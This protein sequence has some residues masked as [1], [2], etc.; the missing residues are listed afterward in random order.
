MHILS[1]SM[2]SVSL[3]AFGAGL[4]FAAPAFASKDQIYPSGAAATVTG[5]TAGID[6]VVDVGSSGHATLD[7]ALYPSQQVDVQVTWSIDN[8]RGNGTNTNYGPGL[9]L[10]FAP[11]LEQTAGPDVAVADIPNCTVTSAASTC[12][13]SIKFTAPT[14]AGNYQIAVKADG[15]NEFSGKPSVYLNF[16]V[17]EPVAVLKDTK[18]AVAKQCVLL[19]A[20]SVALEAKLEELVSGSVIAGASVDFSIDSE[21]SITGTSVTDADG[22]ASL[23]FSVNGLA[24]GD[25]T[26]FAEYAGLGGM[27][28]P[29]A[30]SNTLGVSYLF[31]GFQQPINADGTSV[32]GNGRVIPVKIRLADANGQPVSDAA[33]TVWVHQYT[34]G[35]GLGEVIEAATSVSAADSGNVMRYDPT[36]GQYIY[37]WN[38]DAL[39]NGTYGVVVDVG[40]SAACSQ[41]PYHAVITVARK[42]K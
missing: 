3:A 27:Y 13:R 41:G 8:R 11:S 6:F 20:G 32:F 7:E 38:L 24:V 10:Q 18:L 12:L 36:A 17:A 2:R 39:A 35:T 30:A 28:N 31:G 1:T 15:G 26:I 4:L 14:V 25:H 21:D 9:L 23:P 19:N 5:L 34:T 40:D 29:T 42:K 16:S 37:N 33:P 22:I